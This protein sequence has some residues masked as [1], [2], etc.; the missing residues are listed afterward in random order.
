MPQAYA[1][2]APLTPTQRGPIHDRFE[3]GHGERI[4]GAELEFNS[5]HIRGG[6]AR[7]TRIRPGAS[8]MWVTRHGNRLLPVTAGFH[9]TDRYGYR[10]RFNFN[11]TTRVQP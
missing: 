10:M 5:A 4:L 2:I 8:E 1:T 9:R 6:Q 11:P 7:N 3:S